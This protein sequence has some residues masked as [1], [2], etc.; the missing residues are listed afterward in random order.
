MSSTALLAFLE[1]L[2]K[3]EA[4]SPVKEMN[5]VSF[6]TSAGIITG[7]FKELGVTTVTISQYSFDGKPMG[8]EFMLL[9][10][11]IRGWGINI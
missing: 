3:T 6:L 11:E 4:E 1:N 9:K 2:K 5:S 8:T 7:K 10:D